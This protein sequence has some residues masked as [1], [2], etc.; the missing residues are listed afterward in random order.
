MASVGRAFSRKLVGFLLIA[1]A[2]TFPVWLYD[3]IVVRE[4]SSQQR[5]T[6][7]SPP[8]DRVVVPEASSPQ[9]QPPPLPQ[10]IDLY[11]SAFY[12][13]QE[14]W[15]MSWL[16][17][18]TIQ[19]PNDI[20]V[21]QELISRL[22]PD[23]IVET[24]TWK[25]GSAAIWAMVQDQVNP[26]GRV[27]TIDIRDFRDH[28]ALPPILRSKVDFIVATSSTAP[29]VVADVSRRVAGRSA[30]VLL[31]SDHRKA[32]VLAEMRAYAPLVTVGSYL[33]VQDTNVNG[34]PVAPDFGPGPMEA[35]LEFLAS[36]DRFESDRTQERLLF[37][38][39][40]RGYLRRIR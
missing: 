13:S 29:E 5:Q 39:H 17:I 38:M 30:M 7:P 36:D 20:W 1:A 28:K 22:K 25:G 37:T 9:R 31:D 34:H 6:P 16:G 8:V 11:H 2:A 27:I 21:T 4:T 32:H 18:P 26:R 14:A 35:V 40:P 3:R 10:V 15:K 24:G 33:I 12:K 19:N 23:F